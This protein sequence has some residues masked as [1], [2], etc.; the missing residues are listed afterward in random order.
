MKVVTRFAPSPTGH[1]HL[2]GARTAIFNWLLTRHYN[3]K[4]YLRVEDT[5]TLR[6]E[7]QYTD[8]ILTS[9]RWLGLTWDGDIVYQSK[10]FDIYNEY[11]DKLLESGHAYY[12][13]CSPEEVETMREEARA[14]GEKPRYNGKC[15]DLDLGPGPGRVVRL[16]APR[17]GVTTVDDMV[18]GEVVFENSEFDDMV[19]RKSDGSPT[20][21]LA[22][23]VDDASMGITHVI[24]GDD[25]LTNTPR[26]ILIYQALGLDLPKFGHV[27][28]ILGADKQKLSKRHGAT[29]VI[30]YEKEGL[31]PEALLNYLTLLGWSHGDD[32]IFT[33]DNLIEAFP[34]GKLN[35]SPSAFDPEKLAWLNSE[36]MKAVSDNELAELTEPFIEG[37]GLPLP[38]VE[39]LHD[40]VALF[41]ERAATLK[42][43]ATTMRFMLIDASAIE[44]DPAA[45]AKVLPQGAKEEIRGHIVALAD[46]FKALPDL[47]QETLHEALQNYVQANNLKFKQVG[48]PLRLALVGNLSGPDLGAIMALLGREETLLRLQRF[49]DLC[50]C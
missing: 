9:M 47:T 24:R 1:L 8:S 29:A 14:R 44:Y 2:G 3:G 27:P 28:M 22:V 25:H 17:H 37:L 6:S 50:S 34:H 26:Q 10:R 19:L 18:K 30:D 40:L 35:A 41:R 11:V 13:T 15:R 31:L 12:C 32:E 49:A 36:H 42:E 5:D 33:V 38:S 46:I 43:L 21:N 4:F 16:R 23:V 39:K 7:Q 45:M 48:P 20:Y